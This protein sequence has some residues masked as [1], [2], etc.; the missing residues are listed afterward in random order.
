[1]G[2]ETMRLTLAPALSAVG[3][4]LVDVKRFA[5]AL[6]RRRQMSSRLF[7]EA[8][9]SYARSTADPHTRLAARFAAKEAVMKALGVGL[10]A[11][12]FR[13]IEVVRR[14]NGRPELVL[15]GLAAERA[16]AAGLAS[17][18]VSLTH[19]ATTAGAMVVAHSGA[20]SGGGR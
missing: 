13:D 19:T 2:H 6:E 12:R 20:D 14:P 4:D 5:A 7:T 8:E 16:A 17:W 3:I 15:R 18:Q 10:G 11:C 9:L 1:M